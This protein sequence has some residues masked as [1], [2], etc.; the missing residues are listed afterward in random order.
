MQIG[1][2]EIKNRIFLA[3]MAGITDQPFR[4]LCSQLGAGLTFSEMM[5]TNP[6][7]WHT[8]KSRL[9]L[10][11]HDEIGINAVQISGSDPTEMAQAAKINVEYGADIIDINMGCPAKKVNKKMAGSALLREPELVAQ[12]LNAVVNAVDVPVTLKIRTGWDPE[13]RNCLTIAKIA[14]QAGIKALTIHGRTRSCLFNGEAEYE[15]IK[16]VKQTV[17]IPII[18][19]GDIRSAEK[20]KSVLDYTNVDA[21]MIG[22]GSFGNPWLFKEINDFFETGQYSTLP[23]K[24]KY[25]LMFKHIEDLHQFYGEE[26]GYRIARKHV[27]WYVEQLQPESNFKRTFNTLNSTKEQL[28]ALEDFVKLIL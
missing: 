18:A 12:I 8:E 17:S 10:A 23:E 19:N 1:Q 6:D 4:R 15:S 7:V 3:P 13:N 26:K 27:G 2:Y 25:Q 24:E 11:H 28:N 14:E 9:R 16:A 20:A 5:S 22:R 21:V